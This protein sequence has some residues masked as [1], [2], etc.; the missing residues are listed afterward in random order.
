[1]PALV[2][3]ICLLLVLL[4]CCLTVF[5]VDSFAN[6]ET[7]YKKIELF[8]DVLSLI[9]SNYVE[10]VDMD[11]LVDGAI[12]GMLGTLDPHSSFLSPEMYQ[13]M[14]EETHGEFSGLGIEIA[15]KN[16]SLIVVSPIEDTPAFFAGVKAGDEIV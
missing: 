13:D 9:R 1:M 2:K 11:Q 3:K 6:E 4:G 5:S 7:D 8:T 14:Q 16:G 15:V 10:N 12:R